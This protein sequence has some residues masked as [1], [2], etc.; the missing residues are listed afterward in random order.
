MKSDNN[1]SSIPSELEQYFAFHDLI[2]VSEIASFKPAKVLMESKENED[3]PS[4]SHELPIDLE[5]LAREIRN[6]EGCKLKRFATNTVVGEGTPNAKILIIGEA[7]GEAE[8]INGVPFCG[9]SGQLLENALRR[10][11]L[12]RNK[13]FYITNSVFWRPPGNRKPE[14]EE[15]SVCRPFLERMIKIIN[16][17]LVICVGSVAI[18]NATLLNESISKMRQKEFLF[19]FLHESDEK[20]KVIAFYHPSYLLRSPAKKREAYLD[21]LWLKKHY[22]SLIA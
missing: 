22:G 16:P 10:F 21:L 14:D 1:K 12:F 4:T 9:R 18:Y 5:N 2:G 8:D 15:L 17:E 7:P 6:F 19:R 13:N 20:L 11:K 3:A